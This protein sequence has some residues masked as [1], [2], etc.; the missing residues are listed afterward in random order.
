MKRERGSRSR[1]RS[2]PG[3]AVGERRA[4]AVGVPIA[5][6]VAGSVGGS[7][8]EVAVDEQLIDETGC[9]VLVELGHRFA[10]AIERHLVQ[11]LVLELGFTGE[12]T[13]Q[14]GLLGTAGPR[15]VVARRGKRRRKGGALSVVVTRDEAGFLD[16]AIDGFLEETVEVRDFLGRP[17]EVRQLGLDRDTELVGAVAGEPETFGVVAGEFDSHGW[18]GRGLGFVLGFRGRLRTQ[19]GPITGEVTGPFTSESRSG[20]ILVGFGLF[21]WVG[22]W[23]VDSINHRVDPDEWGGPT[24]A[25]PATRFA[26]PESRT[27]TPEAGDQRVESSGCDDVE[28]REKA[29]RQSAARWRARSSVVLPSRVYNAGGRSFAGYSD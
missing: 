20:G 17:V 3:G 25:S 4:G 21:A 7:L 24:R 12:L 29:P 23:V 13:D 26:N 2:F 27:G 9:L 8:R 18:W 5:V 28:P 11:F 19:K 6:P 1:V 14:F 15:S 10:V 22:S 16:L